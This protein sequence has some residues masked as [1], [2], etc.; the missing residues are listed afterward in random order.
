MNLKKATMLAA[1]GVVYTFIYRSV[2]TLFPGSFTDLQ[3]VQFTLVLSLIASMFLVNFFYSF[4]REYVGDKQ[5]TLKNTAVLAVVGAAALAL[6]DV[7]ELFVVFDVDLFRSAVHSRNLDAIVPLLS[8]VLILSFFIAF[9]RETT[10]QKRSALR[11]ATFLATVGSAVST[12][13]FAFVLFNY[14]YQGTF[15]PVAA[16]FQAAPAAFLLVPAASFAA[17]LYF[18]IVFYREDTRVDGSS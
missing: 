2:A 15:T 14:I 10:R 7:K 1:V 3:V 5:T 12:G 9:Y 6:L 11:K 16:A 8:S 18:F 13:M 4:L 17:V